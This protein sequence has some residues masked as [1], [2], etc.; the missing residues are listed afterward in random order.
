[1]SKK[2]ILVNDMGTTG[3]KAI[4]IDEELNILAS[5]AKEYT[6]YY[7]H[8]NW[9]T[10]K[11]SEVYGTVVECTKKVI[12]N[13]KINVNDIAV[14]SFSNQMMTMIPVDKDGNVLM[15]EVGIWCDMR[16]SEQAKRLMNELGGNDEYYKITGVGWQPEL[17]PICKVMWY[18]KHVPEIYNKTYKFLQYK[19]L[20]TY[21]MTGEMAT[22]YGDISMNGMMDSAKKE[23]SEAI[24]KAADVDVNKIPKIINSHDIVGYVSESAAKEFGIV[25]GTPVTLGSGDVICANIGA[26]V[27]KKGMG[28][29][30][31]GS[32]NWSAVFSEKPVL[33]PKYKMNCNTMQPTGGYNLVMITAAG[34]I[35]QDW[36]KDIGYATDEVIIRDILNKSVYDKMIEDTKNIQPGAEG[37]IF[38]PYLRGGGAPHFDMNARGSFLGLSMV[39]NRAHM[40]RAIYEGICFNMRWLYDL[41]EDLGISIYGLDRIRA[42]GGGVLNDLWMQIYANVNNMSFSRL[43]S[44]QQSTALGAAVIGGVG[45]GIWKDYE[46]ATSKIT[47]DKTFN[48]DKGIH[49]IYNDLYDIY[50]GSYEKIYSIFSNFSEFNEKYAKSN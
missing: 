36:F 50:R 20:I 44:P 18:K 25:E 19:E 30:Y 3:N 39:H 47:I 11:I 46:E 38:F 29:T 32:A 4:I 27:I 2:Y 45:V 12:A 17:A 15:D 13:S 10:Q 6:T 22:E 14:V 48:P 35:A 37:L 40:L 23:I 49:E 8:L 34:G 42:I 24:F 16:Q 21:K 1:M 28:Y 26:G 7:P 41:Y 43:S 5:E 31:I 9:S 33:D